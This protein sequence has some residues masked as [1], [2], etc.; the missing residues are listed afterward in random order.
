MPPAVIA[1]GV[2]AVGAIGGAVIGSSAQKKAASQAAQTQQQATDAQL[3]LGQQ[4][5]AVQQQLAQQSLGQQRDIYNSNYGILS[6]Y[7]SRGNV[8]GDAINALL[9]LPAAPVMKS[10]LAGSSAP[11]SGTPA[12]TT[13]GTLP[14]PSS[15]PPATGG[16]GGNPVYTPGTPPS[17]Q[18]AMPMAAAQG[19]YPAGV[20]VVG[21]TDTGI[22]LA[23]TQ[24]IAN[25]AT[26][27]MAPSTR[28]PLAALNARRAARGQPPVGH[29]AS[30]TP[31]TPSTPSAPSGT[32]T[33]PATGGAH[34]ATGG[35]T[36]PATTGQTAQ[37]AMQN[38]ANSAG[39]QFQLQQGTNALNNL[40]AA[41]GMLQSGAAMKGINNYAQQ[42]ALNNYF[43]PYM[44][45]LGGQQA[46]GA[47]AASS[48]AGVGNNF[49]NSVTGINQGLAN[50]TTGINAGMGSAINSGAQNIGNLQLAN[51]QNQAN[52]WGTIG[53]ALGGLASSFVPKP[54]Y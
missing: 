15:P 42:T 3:Q 19:F 16:T 8:A 18:T 10:P 4:S 51:G 28:D 12:P 7:A 39:M 24:T 5:L 40:Y 35:T 11:A 21:Y 30:G 43:M 23:A 13:G 9:G 31:A 14:L 38:F 20:N 46:V 52:M 33:P 50:A 47:G 32:T 22:P 45:L 53:G 17:G 26:G 54:T 49:A 29:T 44:S 2:G 6:P 27:A 25:P 34:P 1:A 48:V 37:Q 41:H 36:A